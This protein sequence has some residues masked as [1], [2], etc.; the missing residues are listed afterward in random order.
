MKKRPAAKAFEVDEESRS[1]HVVARFAEWI[2]P[3]ELEL[4]E[5]DVVTGL[6]GPS[7]EDD[8]ITAFEGHASC[9][10]P[11]SNGVIPIAGMAGLLCDLNIHGVTADKVMR[12][13]RLIAAHV[14]DD[15]PGKDEQVRID[16]FKLWWAWNYLE[17]SDIYA[18]LT[19]HKTFME[20]MG[21]A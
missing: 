20:N 12:D 1:S 10:L 17:S 2:A 14:T 21:D 3:W 19:D 11:E 8:I 7:Y 15:V 13:I 16:D 9:K 18:A 4:D 5:R 6:I